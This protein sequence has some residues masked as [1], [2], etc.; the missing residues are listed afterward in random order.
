MGVA[1]ISPMWKTSLS[2]STLAMVTN[3]TLY[4]EYKTEHQEELVGINRLLK[5]S[6]EIEKERKEYRNL[7]IAK[8]EMCRRLLNG[9][10]SG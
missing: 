4:E 6:E 1:L 10:H 7:K 3:M 5:Y 8:V 2:A 9:D